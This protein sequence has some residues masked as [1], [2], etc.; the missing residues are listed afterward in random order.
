[1]T[2]MSSRR[3]YSRLRGIERMLTWLTGFKNYQVGGYGVHQSM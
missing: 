1:M 2:V 3:L